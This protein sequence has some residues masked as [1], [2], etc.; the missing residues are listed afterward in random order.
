[1]ETA[2]KERAE[3]WRRRIVAQQAGGQSIRAWCRA[4]G[5]H[6]QSF[7]Q[8]RSRL[9]LCPSSAM[10]RRRRRAR[11]LEFAEVVVDRAACGPPAAGGAE[12]ICLRLGGG[13]ELV[14]PGSMPAGQL[15]LLIRELEAAQ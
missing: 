13:R 15:A 9:G 1:M 14:L 8:W 10:K 11:R 4:N 2:V 7:Y 5:C 6:E 3:A 12:P